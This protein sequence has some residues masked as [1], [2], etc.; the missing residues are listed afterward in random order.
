M[1]VL[2]HDIEYELRV[3]GLEFFVR[4]YVVLKEC[5]TWGEAET[6]EL[7]TTLEF[8]ASPLEAARKVE[9]AKT[10]FSKGAQGYALAHAVLST[11]MPLE[12]VYEAMRLLSEE[13]KY[14]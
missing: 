13:T 9:A 11:V 8:C 12:V 5:S 1:S 3:I 7:L 2:E 10:I 14:E 4:N 6:V